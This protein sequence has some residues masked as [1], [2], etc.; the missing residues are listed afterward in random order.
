MQCL[1][2][3]AKAGDC[4]VWP[5]TWP[6]IHY[7]TVCAWRFADGTAFVWAMRL[8]VFS[9][10]YTFLLTTFRFR[11]LLLRRCFWLYIN[12]LNWTVGSESMHLYQCFFT[13]EWI[14]K[15]N[16][17]YWN[18]AHIHRFSAMDLTVRISAE[19]PTFVAIRCHWGTVTELDYRWR[20]FVRGQD[21]N[22]CEL[23]ESLFWFFSY[24][25]SPRSVGSS[26]NGF[27]SFTK[28]IFA[29]FTFYL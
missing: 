2:S 6:G 21:L 22:R 9:V 12:L 20:E 18:M 27:L 1:K 7:N 26:L 11:H 28:L 17:Y 10:W 23:T 25:F 19:Q 5:L 4:S 24:L 16:F 8:A 14:Q 15:I 13:R 29:G 3:L